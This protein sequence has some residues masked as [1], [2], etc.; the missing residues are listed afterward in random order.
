[1]YLTTHTFVEVLELPPQYLADPDYFPIFAQDLHTMPPTYL[2][3]AG[4]DP[5]VD[6]VTLFDRLLREQG[7]KTQIKVYKVSKMIGNY[8]TLDRKKNLLDQKLI[9]DGGAGDASWI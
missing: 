4:C 9:G 3:G 7:V 6:D 5:M 8:H 1:M 2:V